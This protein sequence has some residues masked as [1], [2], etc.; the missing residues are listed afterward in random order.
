MSSGLFDFKFKHFYHVCRAL[1][2][3]FSASCLLHTHSYKETLKSYDHS[4]TTA[5]FF[6]H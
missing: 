1:K 6:D 3:Y 4:T 2:L 5:I